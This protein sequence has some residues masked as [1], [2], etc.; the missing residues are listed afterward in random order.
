MIDKNK[1]AEI[2]AFRQ[3]EEERKKQEEIMR[4]ISLNQQMITKMLNSPVNP[5]K[6]MP[7]ADLVDKWGVQETTFINS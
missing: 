5:I 7:N 1:R 4:R 3:Q 2:E 6:F